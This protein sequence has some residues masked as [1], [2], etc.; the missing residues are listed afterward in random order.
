[1]GADEEPLSLS[2]IELLFKRIKIIAA[3]KMAPNIS[4]KLWIT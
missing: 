2:L 4:M 3:S 1:M